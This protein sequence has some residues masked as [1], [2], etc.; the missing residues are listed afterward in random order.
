MNSF[1]SRRRLLMGLVLFPAEPESYLEIVRYTSSGSFF[2]PEDGFFEIELHGASGCGGEAKTSGE[3]GIPGGGGGGGGGC[4]VSRI[5]MKKDDKI[6]FVL[7]KAT[8]ESS[9]SSVEYS[10]DSS[11]VIESSF[12]E[13]DSTLSVSGGANGYRTN[14]YLKGKGGE[15]GKASGGNFLNKN[16]G[17]GKD[18]G[19]A[20]FNWEST[21]FG[22]EGG[23]AGYSGGN[24]GGKGADNSLGSTNMNRGYG[25]DAFI[26]I[27]R[28][29]NNVF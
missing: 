26:V 15:G 8:E 9:A 23:T 10:G 4:A 22:G 29:N 27:R 25:K 12:D 17:N 7:G 2:A 13:Y 6:S 3:E 14:G 19:T 5:K 18:G 20:D 11:A 28:G 24:P 1:I 16:G 21:A